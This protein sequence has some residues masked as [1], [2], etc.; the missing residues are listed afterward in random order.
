MGPTGAGGARHVPQ[1][2]AVN[3][4]PPAVRNGSSG[5]SSGRR[6]CSTQAFAPRKLLQMSEPKFLL[7]NFLLL[8]LSLLVLHTSFPGSFLLA[9]FHLP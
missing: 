6:L 8:I 9:V 1:G 7:F 2:A 5:L 3:I 4:S